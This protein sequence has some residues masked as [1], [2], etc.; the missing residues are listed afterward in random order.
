MDHDYTYSG[1]VNRTYRK[2]S[3]IPVAVR[4]AKVQAFNW[5]ICNIVIRNVVA[6]LVPAIVAE[7]QG[8]CDWME[9]HP[10]N[11]SDACRNIHFCT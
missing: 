1:L 2:M 7:V 11:V 4:V 8:V 6:N 5:R 3:A 10:N 9:L